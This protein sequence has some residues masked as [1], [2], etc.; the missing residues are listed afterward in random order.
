VN[1]G[2]AMGHP[3]FVMSAFFT[4]QT[5]A[6]IELYARQD[7]READRVPQGPG[8]LYRREAGRAVQVGALPLLSKDE[9][10]RENTGLKAGAFVWRWFVW[11][12]GRPPVSTN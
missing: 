8:R 2:N 3:C 12:V 7:R 4:N 6:Q 10:R 1:L 9:I 5:L 11:C